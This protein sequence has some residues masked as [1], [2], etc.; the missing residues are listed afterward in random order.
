MPNQIGAFLK[1]SECFASLGINLT[2]VNYNKAIDSHT[3]FIDA[4]G[5]E[6]QLRK[7]D[8]CLNKIGY[9]TN[10]KADNNIIL[11]EFRLRNEPGSVTDI[12]KLITNYNFNI[13][14]ISS[15]GNSTRH[16]YLKIGLFVDNEDNIS[17]FINEAGKLCKV[18]I[19]DY[20]QA[21]KVYD[22]S[23][24]YNSFV[25]GLTKTIDLSEEKKTELMVNANL[26]MQML[27]ERGLSPYKTFDNIGR[28]AD[29]I[30]EYRHEK[31]NP[32]ITS[33]Q[34]TEKTEIIT[35]EPP[36]GSNTIIIK[37]L[38]EIL[39][40]DCGYAL[41]KEEML[42]IF[43][44]ICPDFDTMEK[45]ILITHADID[46]CGLLSLFDEV[47][48][49]KNSAECL[50][51]EYEKKYGYREQIQ[52]H[53]PYVRICKALTLYQPPEPSLVKS[54]WDGGENLTELL[55]PVGIFNI[56]ELH[57]EV[58][59]GK[60]GHLKGETVLLDY[61]H[62]IAFTGDIYINIHEL[63]PE[64][65]EYNKYAPM[66]MTSVDTDPKLCAMERKAI[67]QR[68]GMG[69]WQIFGAHGARK[70]YSVEVH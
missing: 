56:G 1:A 19:I 24:F 61:K 70:L 59:E 33:H 31:F 53:L 34:I 32:R 3:M 46:H 2:R 12:L 21:E 50:R 37:S 5:T 29:H 68:L 67:M 47:Y 44:D 7:A 23:I 4:E 16:Q 39:F 36:C 22:N 58:Y 49:T 63:T 62:H 15:N 18:K 8:I 57:F 43:R 11:M 14:Y 26:A 35:I 38:G 13:S 66:L 10:D 30:A 41:Y 60:G 25:L 64:Q 55:T 52:D 42:K 69:N 20:N 54:L 65:R 17:K 51:L 27:D 9:L 6:E 45:K 28:F 48:A 40:V